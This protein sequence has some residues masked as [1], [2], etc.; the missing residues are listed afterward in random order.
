MSQLGSYAAAASATFDAGGRAVIVIPGPPPALSWW[1]RT[2]AVTSTSG[3]RT[4][5]TIY[6]N[7]ALPSNVIDVAPASG[8][9]DTS[10]IGFAIG[11]GESLVIVWSGGTVGAVA[12]ATLTYDTE[13]A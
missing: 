6:R 2:V 3:T 4:A 13:A 7:S 10:S 8:N 12:T 9:A 11:P 5:A 1:V